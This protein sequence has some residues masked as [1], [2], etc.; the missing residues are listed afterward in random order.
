MHSHSNCNITDKIKRI[1]NVVPSLARKRWPHSSSGL[2]ILLIMWC[3]FILAHVVVETV[4]NAHPHSPSL[5]RD[6]GPFSWCRTCVSV[7]TEKFLHVC[8]QRGSSPSDGQGRGDGGRGTQG[9]EYLTGARWAAFQPQP[10]PYFPYEG[11]TASWINLLQ[12]KC[13]VFCRS[14]EECR[15][16]VTVDLSKYISPPTLL[17]QVFMQ[18]ISFQVGV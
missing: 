12:R 18:W 1:R 10:F 3:D 17:F 4:R 16:L 5:S 8:K 9:T 2:W 6:R 15:H 11:S 13:C 14:R 7:S